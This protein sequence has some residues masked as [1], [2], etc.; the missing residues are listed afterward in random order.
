MREL[1]RP[2]DQGPLG[3]AVLPVDRSGVPILDRRGSHKRTRVAAQNFNH[4]YRPERR[5]NDR[6][7][8]SARRKTGRT[9]NIE[10]LGLDAARVRY[11]PKGIDVSAPLGRLIFC[12]FEQA[13]ATDSGR[14]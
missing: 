3:P 12:R 2:L 13:S 9:P 1:E 6:R 5:T 11:A 14:R 10:D 4:V 8:A 7:L